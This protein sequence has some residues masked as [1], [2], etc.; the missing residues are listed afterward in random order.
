MPA[1]RT[2][3]P[4]L[5]SRCPRCRYDLSG[6]TEESTCP[7]C[8]LAEAARRCQAMHRP[9]NAR[10]LR[11]LRTGLLV[12]LLRQTLGPLILGLWLL[13]ILTGGL[14]SSGFWAEAFTLAAPVICGLAHIGHL[15]AALAQ[16]TGLDHHRWA[17]FTRRA[18]L[19]TTGLLLAIV[20]F[21]LAVCVPLL[22]SR[23]PP[24][25]V[26]LCFFMLVPLIPL[27]SATS[28]LWHASAAKLMLYPKPTDVALPTAAWLCGPAYFVMLV[29]AVLSPGGSICALVA[30][31][32]AEWLAA[33]VA[34][35]ARE[36]LTHPA[37]AAAEARSDAGGTSSV[38]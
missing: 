13:W 36:D 34:A 28:A 4:P 26:P 18:S 19:V 15:I 17:H 16:P 3:H 1:P 29:V 21:F 27:S 2:D 7:E 33:G 11:R 9:D 6:L 25:L 35:M 14:R 22:F 20:G 10:A 12:V 31:A 5:G 23:H 30:I 8:G 37:E 24:V 32:A 38:A